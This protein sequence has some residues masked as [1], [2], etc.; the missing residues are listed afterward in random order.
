[1][2]RFTSLYGRTRYQ[3][4]GVSPLFVC[5]HEQVHPVRFAEDSWSTRMFA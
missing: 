2:S 1:M 3:N 5:G 4:S